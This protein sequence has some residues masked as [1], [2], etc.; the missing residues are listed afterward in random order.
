M[1][2]QDRREAGQ[3]LA[4]FLKEKGFA[5]PVVL[6]IPRGGVPVAAEV[7]R[8]LDGELGVV[9]A[10]KLGAPGNPELAIG[11]TTETGA[12]Y[13]NTALAMAAGADQHYIEAEKARQVAEAHRREELFDGH[14]RRPVAGRTVIIVDDGIATGA[15][16]IAAVRS[17]K[18]LGAARVVL[19][20]PVGP[21]ETL[22]LLQAEADQVVCLHEDPGFWAVGLYYDDFSQVSDDE[23]RLTLETFAS[24]VAAKAGSELSCPVRVERDG[25]GLAAVLTV[26]AAVGAFPLVIFVH[27]LGSSKESPR[28]L[29]IASRLVESGIATLL[30]DLSNHGASSPDPRDGI[31][32]Y[33][34]DLAAVFAWALEQGEIVKDRVGIA[35][36]SLGAVATA[37][38]LAVGKVRPQTLVLRAPP[39]EAADFAKV[40][41]PSLVLIGS[42]DPLRQQVEA[43]IA[44]R[45]Q[46]TLS[47]VAGAGHLFEEPGTLDEATQRTVAWF[48]SRLLQ[49]AHDPA[50]S[51]AGHA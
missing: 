4:A 16:A 13:I 40:T 10:R 41:V 7:A 6:G 49:P 8:A 19:A 46:L 35:G 31:D 45:P 5:K 27:G 32:A 39:L 47:V 37:K 12:S 25:I 29:V 28:N 3:R 44:G 43:G 18:A 17:I 22:R 1:R 51:A 34:A 14:R 11:A 38:A 33:A 9:V 26:P 42:H 21:T 48:T 24:Q 30:F 2:F 50:P 36:S 15:T 23:A 20:V